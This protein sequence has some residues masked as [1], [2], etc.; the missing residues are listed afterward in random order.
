MHMVEVHVSGGHFHQDSMKLTLI[1]KYHSLQLD[2][3]IV[4]V[5]ANC[6]KCNGF[7]PANLHSLLD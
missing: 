3:S 5:I 4:T 2:E 7:G 6:A 1:D